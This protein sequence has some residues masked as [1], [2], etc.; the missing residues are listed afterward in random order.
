MNILLV[1]IYL[2]YCFSHSY[3]IHFHIPEYD[4]P[5]ESQ[6]NKEIMETITRKGLN[7]GD[8]DDCDYPYED[9]PKA[10]D[11]TIGNRNSI[12]PSSTLSNHHINQTPM[13]DNSEFQALLQNRNQLNAA[14]KF[15]VRGFLICIFN[16]LKL[17]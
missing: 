16:C 9:S 6:T 4:Q 7:G 11:H 5:H 12:L 1:K 3:S 14:S 17:F 10:D 8:D 2:E 15:S 13:H